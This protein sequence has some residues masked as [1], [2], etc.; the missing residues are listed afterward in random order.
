[1]RPGCEKMLKLEIIGDARTLI[2]GNQT[3]NEYDCT[4][5][6]S[7]PLEIV[8]VR[9]DKKYGFVFLGNHHLTTPQGVFSRVEASLLL[10]TNGN[11]VSLSEEVGPASDKARVK[12]M[13]IFRRYSIQYQQGNVSS[14]SDVVLGLFRN[15][16]GLDELLHTIE[17]S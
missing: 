9:V 3:V 16:K 7:K 11:V 2:D 12:V 15:G 8:P 5:K 14:Q 6:A 1:M 10:G 4:I 17:R 13:N